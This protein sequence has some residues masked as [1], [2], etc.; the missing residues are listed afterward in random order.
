MS[1]HY[2]TYHAIARSWSSV[3]FSLAVLYAS[4]HLLFKKITA[5][6]EAGCSACIGPFK[7]YA[8][9]KKVMVDS[10]MVEKRLHT[11]AGIDLELEL[12]LQHT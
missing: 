10:W 8:G 2:V 4:S 6:R 5:Q 12:D 11:T 9:G 7:V 3:I 1:P